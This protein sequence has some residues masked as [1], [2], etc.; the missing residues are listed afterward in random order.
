MSLAVLISMMNWIVVMEASLGELQN[1][2]AE[3]QLGNEPELLYY[4]RVLIAYFRQDVI[5]LVSLRGEVPNLLL[6]YLTSM[7]LEVRKTSTDLATIE[8]LKKQVQEETTDLLFLGEAAFI[9][10]VAHQAAKSF[11]SSEKYYREAAAKLKAGGAKKKALRALMSSLAAYSCVYP[12]SRLF[13]E[14]MEI[15]KQ[16]MEIMDFQ[17]AGTV[18]MN[19]SREFQRLDGLNIA[20]DYVT[21]SIVLFERGAQGSREHGLSLV[22]RAH[23]YL[24]LHRFADAENDFFLALLNPNVEVQSACEVLSEKYHLN[25]K[26]LKSDRVLATWQERKN[27]A[28]TLKPLGK[29]ESE[30][31]LI[32][33]KKPCTKFEL[34]DALYGTLIDHESKENRLKNLMSRVRTRFP[35]LILLEDSS[36]RISEPEKNKIPW[37]YPS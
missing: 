25:L 19:I 11:V 20:L 8:S 12:E 34:M 27:E 29:L 36:Y 2:E 4:S 26:T 6:S 30:L 24:Q 7:R 35:G 33:S 18:Q 21:Q 37:S 16:A 15:Y 5:A 13:A 23:L 31:I 22:H 14:Y 3:L 10:A 9:A 1:I 32:L 17:T 28:G